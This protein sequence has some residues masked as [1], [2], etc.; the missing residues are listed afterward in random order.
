MLLIFAKNNFFFIILIWCKIELIILKIGI[1]SEVM[2]VYLSFVKRP[3]LL[4]VKSCLWST[5][6]DHI[7]IVIRCFEL[8]Q[9]EPVFP[10]MSVN[11]S[12][13]APHRFKE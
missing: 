3:C 11:L 4:K 6:L 13:L 5:L 8:K 7:A 9:F 2:A 10:K 12:V 1:Y